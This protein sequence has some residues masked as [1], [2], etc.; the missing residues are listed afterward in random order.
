MKKENESRKKNDQDLH[1]LWPAGNIGLEIFYTTKR[2]KTKNYN[3]FKRKEKKK[4]KRKRK[5]DQDLYVLT[6]QNRSLFRDCF[7]ADTTL[8]LGK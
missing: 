4:R 1:V 8:F 3:F 7:P 6:L 5:K 2:S